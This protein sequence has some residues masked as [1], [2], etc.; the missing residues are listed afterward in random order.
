L[1]INKRSYFENAEVNIEEITKRYV[2]SKSKEKQKE[3]EKARL[4][5]D[6]KKNYRYGR[7]S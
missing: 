3:E 2:K 7:N 1:R 4:K 6:I 5:E